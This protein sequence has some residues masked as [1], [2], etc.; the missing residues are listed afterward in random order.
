[1]RL[2]PWLIAFLLVASVSPQAQWE[3]RRNTGIPRLADGKPDLSAPAPRTPDGRLDLSGMWQK[4]AV[5][6][7]SQE[8]IAV[9]IPDVPMQPWAAALFD[10]R[11]AT[12]G[13]AHPRVRCLPRG[14]PNAMAWR[15]GPFKFIHTP[16]VTLILFEE[17][18]TYRQ[19]FTDGRSLPRDPE[20]AWWG[21]SVG[22]WETDAFVVE[23]AGLKDM[24][25]LDFEGHPGTE[26]MR[27]TERF[28]RATVGDMEMEITFDDPKAYTRAW[29]VKNAFDFM[30]DTEFLEHVCENEF[31]YQ[32]VSPR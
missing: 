1:M 12:K 24:Q 31:T 32:R 21:Y 10:E 15:P 3:D 17:F 11:R 5:G 23:T 4:K 18:V 2:N 28:R 7:L 6:G 19:V 14:I 30:P 27:I 25:W 16:S 22:R 29:S 8:N 20:P 9:G 13:R 26:A